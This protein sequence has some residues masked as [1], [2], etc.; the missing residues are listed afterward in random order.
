MLYVNLSAAI[1]QPTSQGVMSFL[2]EQVN[3]GEK[4][5][6]FLFASPGGAVRD[7]INLYNFLRSLPAKIIMHNIGVVDSIANVVFLAAEDRYANPV[8]SFLFHGVGFDITQSARL[9]EKDLRERLTTIQRDQRLIAEVI[10]ERTKLEQEEIMGMFL[11]AKTRTPN[12]AREVGIIQDVKSA[13]IPKGSQ[14]ITLRF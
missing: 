5:F 8:S 2:T 7:G 4:E 1:N 13:S 14:I 12:E 10:A 9:E 3:K 6:Y 11:E